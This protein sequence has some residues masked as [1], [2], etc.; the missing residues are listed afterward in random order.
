MKY[1]ITVLLVLLLS[2]ELVVAQTY[3]VKK[4]CN[5]MQIARVTNN[6]MLIGIISGYVAGVT[7]TYRLENNICPEFS[8]DNKAY[9]EYMGKFLLDLESQC[10]NNPSA[11]FLN[12][13]LVPLLEENIKKCP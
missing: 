1:I 8:N 7:E 6:R 4:M 11:E 12:Q 13:S 10:Q 9:G 5:E 2:P 3:S